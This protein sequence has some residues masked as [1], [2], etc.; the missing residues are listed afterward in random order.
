MQ[1][2]LLDFE[3]SPFHAFKNIL[4]DVVFWSYNHL[5]CKVRDFDVTQA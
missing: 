2:K 3:Y 5:M 4:P 1:E